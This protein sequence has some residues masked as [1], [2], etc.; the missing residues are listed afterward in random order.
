MPQKVQFGSMRGK[1]LIVVGTLIAVVAPLAPGWTAPAGAQAGTGTIAGTAGPPS[2]PPIPVG[3]CVQ[4]YDAV[5]RQ[6]VGVEQPSG[7]YDHHYAIT[8]P[9]GDYVVLF[10]GCGGRW[11]NPGV[12]TL[13]DHA[14]SWTDAEVVSVGAGQTVT[15]NGDLNPSARTGGRVEDQFGNG[16]PCDFVI[17]ADAADPLLFDGATSQLDGLY[18]LDGVV[19]PNRL[20]VDCGP[21]YDP[22]FTD[23]FTLAPGSTSRPTLVVPQH[24]RSI[25]GT[26]TAEGGIDVSCANVVAFSLDGQVIGSTQA[27]DGFQSNPRYRRWVLTDLPAG[28]VKLGFSPCPEGIGNSFEPEWLGDTT[29]FEDATVIDVPADDAVANVHATVARYTVIEG[30]F[31]DGEGQP[32]TGAC[33]W[34]TD[35]D[36]T[37]LLGAAYIEFGFGRVEGLLPVGHK[38]FVSDCGGGWA[39]EWYLDQPD[40][41]SADVIALPPGGFVFTQTLALA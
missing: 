39:P 26:V 1:L 16:L 7:I 41:A 4:A 11:G 38:V 15:V 5:T 36:V 24:D 2:A 27:L 17:Y 23:P 19:G 13:Y 30:T 40:A 34:V 18:G 35:P 9:A 8:V 31:V 14:T 20:A 32:V 28:P 22:V 33:M 25:S 10:Y 21:G 6:P 3:T 29:S 37:T 12:P